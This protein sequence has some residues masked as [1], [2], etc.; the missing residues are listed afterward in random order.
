MAKHMMQV[1]LEEEQYQNVSNAAM[2]SGKD[3]EVWLAEVIT[4][5][6]NP[7]QRT[8][9]TDRPVSL[10]GGRKGDTPDTAQG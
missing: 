8:G 5:A 4:A 10:A 6:A 7:S 3:V 9:S 2:K 1:A